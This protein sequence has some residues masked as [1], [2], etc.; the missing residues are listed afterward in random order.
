MIKSYWKP[1]GRSS[2]LMALAAAL[3]LLAVGSVE[4][5]PSPQS[6]SDQN[7]MRLA[8]KKA[9]EAFQVIKSERLKRGIEID[10]VTDPAQ[11]GMLG[12]LISPVTSNHGVLPAK[13]ATVNPNF[14]AVVVEMLKQAG[15]KP[16]DT[17]AVG[18]SGSFPALN[19]SVIAA[20]E[21]LDV[22][23][24]IISSASGSQWGANHPDFLWLDMEAALKEAGVIS[25]RSIAASL[26]GVDDRGVGMPDQGIELLRA[27][28]DRN[29]L[30]FIEPK[31]LTEAIDERMRLY[32]EHAQGD[33]IKAYLNVGGGT[34]SV[35]THEGK[36]QFEPGFNRHPP[37]GI[38]LVDS[39][40]ARFAA[41]DVPVIHMVQVADLA[42]RYGLPLQVTAM[43]KVGEGGVYSPQKY[44]RSLAAGGL[45]IILLVLSLP[46]VL[47]G[48]IRH[49]PDAARDARLSR[50]SNGRTPRITRVFHQ[51]M[52]SDRHDRGKHAP[53]QIDEEP[54]L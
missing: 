32:R 1:Q 47:D 29:E 43:P 13:Q 44:S 20:L 53:S 5:F 35:G 2:A 22:K 31:D 27:A 19:I 28:V 25:T 12:E 54:V 16:G 49:N 48:S 23:P 21:T 38:D 45:L 17:V 24:L 7:E 26:G 18:F 36:A 11:S 10:P 9:N 34:A 50:P 41:E 51:P 42:A 37:V 14:A 15:L 30:F 46:T 40:M 4:L 3:S 39:V 6:L 33:A 8:A 52:E